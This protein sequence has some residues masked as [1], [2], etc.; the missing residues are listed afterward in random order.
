MNET[1]IF[2]GSLSEDTPCGVS[3]INTDQ[4]RAIQNFSN[5]FVES[6]IMLHNASS[7]IIVKIRAKVYL[8]LPVTFQHTLDHVIQALRHVHHP[9]SPLRY[10]SVQHP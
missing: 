2:H 1:D 4:D 9:Q 8:K 5:H 3:S 6:E 7:T 10:G